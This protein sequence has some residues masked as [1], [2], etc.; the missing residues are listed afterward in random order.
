MDRP[1]THTIKLHQQKSWLRELW[2][3]FCTFATTAAFFGVGCYFESNAMQWFAFVA[4][5]L[6]LF[7]RAAALTKKFT[8]QECADWL[9]TEFDVTAK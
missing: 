8:P 7:G 1:K 5:F 3:D 9:K 2:S 4:T 6:I